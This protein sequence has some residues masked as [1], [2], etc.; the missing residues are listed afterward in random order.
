MLTT[1]GP[2][3]ISP[4]MPTKPISTHVERTAHT[5]AVQQGKYDSIDL[6]HAPVGE[7][8]TFLEVVSRLSQ[9]VKTVHT[10]GDIQAIK[11]QLRSG[12]YQPDAMAM[13][14]RMLLGD[15]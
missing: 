14:A 11:G 12:Q 9:E 3:G 15:A 2:G 13:A 7:R 10:T 4:V 5:E 6:S 1:S 8:R